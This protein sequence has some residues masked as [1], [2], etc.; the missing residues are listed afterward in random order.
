MK[1][2]VIETGINVVIARRDKPCLTGEL[3]VCV[4]ESYG[5]AR[6]NEESTI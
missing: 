2:F 3:G 1:K 4:R 5:Q 6:I